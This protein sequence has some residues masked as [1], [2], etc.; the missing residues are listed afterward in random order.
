[1]TCDGNLTGPGNGGTMVTR[2]GEALL[3]DGP[4]VLLLVFPVVYDVVHTV[5]YVYPLSYAFSCGDP[6][7]AHYCSCSKPTTEGMK[8]NT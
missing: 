7:L 3:C 4:W 6:L 8:N 2:E 1:M 5:S